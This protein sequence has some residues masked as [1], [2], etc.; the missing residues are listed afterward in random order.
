[1]L[2]ETKDEIR[3]IFRQKRAEI[4][5]KDRPL[6]NR[7]IV[8]NIFANISLKPKSVIAFYLPMKTEVDL[9]LLMEMYTET[10]HTICLPC[11]EEKDAP[12]IFR[13]YAKGVELVNNPL[14][15]IQEPHKKYPIV[16]PNV[17]ITPLVAFDSAGTRLG[18]GGGYYD[19]TFEHLADISAEFLAVGAAYDCQ[20]ASFL[21]R[22]NTDFPLDA[23][24]TETRVFVFEKGK[25]Y[26]GR[27]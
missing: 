9:S 10:G 23:L 5:E 26:I 16:E 7:E 20:Q 25:P 1:M 19:R 18:M 13:K 22:E 2:L 3:K 27:S 6:K 8:R 24:A 21:R 15:K 11:V 12:M 14:T 4:S 17:I